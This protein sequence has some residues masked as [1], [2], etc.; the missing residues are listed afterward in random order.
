MA[1]L[2]LT[3]VTASA[4][5]RT[6]VVAS[7]DGRYSGSSEIGLILQAFDEHPPPRQLALRMCA[8]VTEGFVAGQPVTAVVTG[9]N[10][11]AMAAC[12]PLV[13]QLT[14]LARSP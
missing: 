13:L 3:H 1:M 2:L 4:T 10:A 6:I 8:G 9:I 14:L 11:I 5:L 12:M 7:D